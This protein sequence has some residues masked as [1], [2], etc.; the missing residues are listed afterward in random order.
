MP[1]DHG[2]AARLSETDDLRI[3]VR[4][5]PKLRVELCRRQPLAKAGAGRIIKLF[6]EVGQALRIAERQPD[7]QAQTIRG[8]ERFNGAQPGGDCGHAA[9]QL[10]SPL[11]LSRSNHGRAHHQ[12]DRQSNQGAGVLPVRRRFAAEFSSHKLTDI[13]HLVSD[14]QPAWAFFVILLL[15]GRFA[16]TFSSPPSFFLRHSRCFDA[17]FE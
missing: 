1:S 10:A 8:R 13:S 7:D 14:P 3:I 5:W 4:R 15:I 2:Q 12:R 11:G 16:T 17:F 9:V 6:E